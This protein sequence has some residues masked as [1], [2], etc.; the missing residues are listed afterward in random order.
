MLE[1]SGR[2]PGKASRVVFGDDAAMME[3]RDFELGFEASDVSM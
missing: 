1:C 2:A 3:C